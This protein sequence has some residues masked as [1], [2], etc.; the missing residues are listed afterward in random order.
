MCHI[1]IRVRSFK[2]P[3]SENKHENSKNYTEWY[4][5]WQVSSTQ[6]LRQFQPCASPRVF[7]RHFKTLSSLG[8]GIC[9]N[10]S[11]RG[12]GVVKGNFIFSN[13]KDVHASLF[14]L[15]FL[16]A[17]DIKIFSTEL[18]NHVWEADLGKERKEN[19]C[20]VVFHSWSYWFCHGW[21]AE[22]VQLFKPSWVFLIAGEQSDFSL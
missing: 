17:P 22:K 1:S 20:F 4:L 6:W 19:C 10:R 12:W 9:C 3:W 16:S 13:L 14:I 8:W 2:K 7:V 11:A 21:K 15:N 18:I 5:K